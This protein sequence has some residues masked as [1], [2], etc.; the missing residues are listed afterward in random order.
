MQA[1]SNNREQTFFTNDDLRQRCLHR[2]RAM[3]QNTQRG[4]TQCGSIRNR[5]AVNGSQQSGSQEQGHS[6]AGGRW[7]RHSR[8]GAVPTS[9]SSPPSGQLMVGVTATG[10]ATRKSRILA[11]DC[12]ANCR[13]ADRQHPRPASRR[14]F[15]KGQPRRAPSATRNVRNRL[16]RNAAVVRNILPAVT[17]DS[18]SVYHPTRQNISF[19]TVHGIS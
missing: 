8:I 3:R 16:V 12:A 4:N 2:F 14:Q 19:L 5:V 11:D 18:F 7:S 17:I 9:A 13:S 10:N 15:P 6:V 1:F